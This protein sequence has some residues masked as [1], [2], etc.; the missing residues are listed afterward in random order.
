MRSDISQQD[1]HRFITVAEECKDFLIG[2]FT[3][4]PRQ[5]TSVSQNENGKYY[6]YCK[7]IMPSF[8]TDRVRDDINEKGLAGRKFTTVLHGG[9]CHRTSTTHKS[10]NKMKDKKKKKIKHGN[11]KKR[12]SG[13]YGVVTLP[14]QNKSS[15]QTMFEN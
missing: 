5:K 10:G 2:S 12:R 14:W 4:L 9:I 15:F 7:N 6:N 13:V 8:I 1:W 11:S 3:D